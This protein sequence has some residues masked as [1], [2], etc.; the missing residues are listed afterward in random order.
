MLDAQDHHAVGIDAV[1]GDVRA[2]NCAFA[3][4][5]AGDLSAAIGKGGEAVPGLND[6]VGYV[7]RGI[8][9]EM[10]DVAADALKVGK[11]RKRPYDRRHRGFGTGQGNSSGVPHD[12][13]HLTTSSCGTT[14]SAATS[15]SASAIVRASAS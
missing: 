4:L 8:G 9:I 5:S 6:P 2:G 10:S 1:P 12:R 15:A 7:A 11:C 3:K 14:R 13:S